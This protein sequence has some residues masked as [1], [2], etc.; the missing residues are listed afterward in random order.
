MGRPSCLQ[1]SRIWRFLPSRMID[2]HPGALALRALKADIHGLGLV[3]ILE[4]HAAL[5]GVELVIVGSPRQQDAVF[6][7]MSKFRMRELV[8]QL[9]IVGHQHQAFALEV[10]APNRVDMLGDIYQVTDGFPLIAAFRLHRGEHHARLVEGN[11]GQRFHGG[12]RLAVHGDLIDRR[13]R[14]LP[15][16]GDRSIDTH[17]SG[18]D[19]VFT[20]T[21]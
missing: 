12:D 8:G 6:L 5:P 21:A 4:D 18:G 15:Q 11:V 9:A 3:T 13:V 1:V 19:E 7:F 20:G 2:A 10:Q 17:T 14:L 16:L